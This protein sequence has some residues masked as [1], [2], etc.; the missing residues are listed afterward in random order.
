LHFNINY[1]ERQEISYRSDEFSPLTDTDTE[2]EEIR[3]IKHRLDSDE[4][5]EIVA[6]QSRIHPGG[7]ATSPDII[8]ITNKRIIIKN[9]SLLGARENY[10]S[11]TYDKITSIELENGIF[12]SEID[13]YASGY[14]GEIEAIPKDKAEKIVLLVKGKMEQIL[15]NAKEEMRAESKEE[16]ISI[17]DELSKLV[18][19][20]EQGVLSDSEFQKLKQKLL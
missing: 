11:I 10:E 20:R 15:T 4:K 19:L 3:K 13:I 1:L 12:S 18:K 17:A 2:T 5:V 14:A 16:R 8:F 9:P 6:K 7:S